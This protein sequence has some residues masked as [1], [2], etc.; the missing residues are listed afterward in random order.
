MTPMP[1]LGRVRLRHA[2][3][4]SC[5]KSSMCSS[6]N[7]VIHLRMYRAFTSCASN[8]RSSATQRW[9][10]SGVGSAS[11]LKFIKQ[12]PRRPR[13]WNS[14]SGASNEAATKCGACRSNLNEPST[15]KMLSVSANERRITGRQRRSWHALKHAV[16]TSVWK[17]LAIP[18]LMSRPWI[19]NTSPI[20][21]VA[22]HNSCLKPLYIDRNTLN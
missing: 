17:R 20:T 16:R 1:R 22:D 9:F 14:G 2:H 8:H 10:G 13:P 5:L 21:Y 12:K 4:S 6:W 3:V 11:G 15:A 19:W 18:A 7:A